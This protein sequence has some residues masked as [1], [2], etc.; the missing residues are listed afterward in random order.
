M[1]VDYAKSISILFQVSEL[2]SSREVGL[3]TALRII[4]NSVV[5]KGS[6]ANGKK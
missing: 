2:T 1:T 4:L 6:L 5:D 3:K